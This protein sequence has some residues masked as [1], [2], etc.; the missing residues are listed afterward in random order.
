M[1]RIDMAM[2]RSGGEQQGHDRTGVLSPGQ[3][4][5]AAWSQGFFSLRLGSYTQYECEMAYSIEGSL[6]DT[7][8]LISKWA[9]CTSTFWSEATVQEPSRRAELKPLQET[10][11]F[12]QDS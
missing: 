10:R 4:S 1:S 6:S 7:P 3:G 5:Q 12:A 8:S 2:I 9:W 11:R